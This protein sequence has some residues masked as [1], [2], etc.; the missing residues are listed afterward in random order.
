MFSAGRGR[1]WSWLSGQ[2]VLHD[3]P[4]AEP[5]SAPS[6]PPHT[7]ALPLR[8]DPAGD[9]AGTRAPSPLRHSPRRPQ[10]P[11]PSRQ[12]PLLGPEGRNTAVAD[13]VGTGKAP[14]EP[15]PSLRPLKELQAHRPGRDSASQRATQQRSC[16]SASVNARSRYYGVARACARPAPGGSARVMRDAAHPLAVLAA[17]MRSGA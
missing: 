13:S 1:L 16:K 15:P 3:P 2:E 14:Q 11:A 6:A 7:A 12:R 17:A 9:A 8:A 4:G 10:A 5:A